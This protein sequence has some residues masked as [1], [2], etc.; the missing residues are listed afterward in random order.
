[1]D[2]II[3]KLK[4]LFGDRS[5]LNKVLF[6]LFILAAFRA[7]AAIP[8]PGI[9]HA[10]LAALLESGSAFGQL[11]GLVNL[12]SGGVLSQLSI[13]MLGVGPYITGSI[14]MQLITVMSPKLKAMYQ[15]EDGDGARRRFIQYGRMLTVP[16]ALVQGWSFITLLERQ[17]VLSN[18]DTVD[19]IIN[20][21][22]ITAG[23]VILMWLGELISEFGIGNGVSV[24]I[25][26]GIVAS[27]PTT[28]VQTI[29]SYD[30]SQI[31]LYIAFVVLSAVLILG[32]VFITEGERPIPV[33]YAKQVRGSKVSGGVS[34]YLPIRLTQTGVMPIIFALSILVFPQ[35][36]GNLLTLTDNVVLNV[37]ATQINT[38][39]ANPWIYGI[40][41]FVLVVVFTYFYTFI[42]FEPT[43][44]SNNLQKS[45]AFVPGVRPGQATADFLGTII[46]R[47]TLIGAVFLGII[48][49]FPTIVQ[50]TFQI[51]TLSIGG[52]ALL[53]VV[54]VVMDVIKK[55]NAQLTAREY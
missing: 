5:I 24:I 32:V 46:T 44:I 22:V 21:L 49:V 16:L 55:T 47:L 10:Q 29:L 17:A 4:I 18:I 9:D 33:T 53:I 30:V 11:I 3:R 38:W 34:T 20:V 45:G 41:Y 51:A 42:V 23:S 39:L 13:V 35:V 8:V 14:V 25:F 27:L 52:T 28:I 40:L 2:Q 37:Y 6:T 12:F 7:L 50:H 1:M 19:K 15:G 26:A 48:A 36:I 54:S 43:R 31:P